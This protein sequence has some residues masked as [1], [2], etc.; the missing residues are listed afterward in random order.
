[1]NSAS[2]FM[3]FAN[4][5]QLITDLSLIPYMM[6]SFIHDDESGSYCLNEVLTNEDLCLI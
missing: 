1:M 4:L 6:G 2:D 5:V 3:E